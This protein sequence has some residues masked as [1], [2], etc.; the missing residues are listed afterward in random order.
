MNA[1]TVAKQ[2]EVGFSIVNM[3]LTGGNAGFYRRQCQLF[4]E[5][6]NPAEIKRVEFGKQDIRGGYSITFVNHRHTVPAQLVFYS[7]DEM[8]GFVIGFNVAKNV[9]ANPFNSYLK[10]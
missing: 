1:V 8:L 2:G 6:M 9:S 3:R 7:K 10:A 5:L 4:A